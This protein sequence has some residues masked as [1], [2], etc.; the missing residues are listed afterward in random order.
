MKIV[1][2]IDGKRVVFED[3]D[4]HQF[5]QDS[6]NIRDIETGEN[7]LIFTN[8]DDAGLAAR[9][10]YEDM[11]NNDPEEFAV[12]IGTENLIKWGLGQYAG[13]GAEQTTSLEE[14]FQLVANHPEEIFDVEQKIR[15]VKCRHPEWKHYTIA[16]KQ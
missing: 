1:L 9:E 6:W 16:F 4:N 5:Y 2:Y 3:E 7:Y 10:Y 15:E 14:W 11:A 13:P 8:Y 12:I